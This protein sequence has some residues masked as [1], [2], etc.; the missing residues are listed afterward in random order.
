MFKRKYEFKPDKFESGALN[1]LYITKKQR[2]A[3]LKWLLMAVF[4]VL[5]GVVQDVILSKVRLFGATFDLMA[6]ALLLACILLDPEIGS[7]FVLLASLFYWFSGSAAG[8]YV[9]ALLTVLGVF[10]GIVRHC[11]LHDSFGSTILCAGAALFLY[12]AA[13]FGVISGTDDKKEGMGAFMEKRTPQ[14]TDR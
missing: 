4:L 10:F 12:E 9:I 7:I 1:K 2:R 3:A 6:A 5:L 8:P 13:L 14:F 11:Y